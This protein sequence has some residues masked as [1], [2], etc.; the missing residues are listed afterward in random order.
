MDFPILSSIILLPSLGAL[1]LFF[2]KGSEGKS[3]LTIKYVALF[4]TITNFIISLYLWYLF[5]ESSSNF[6]FIEDKEWL[7][8]F[9]NYKVGIDGISILFIILTTF[10]TPLCVLSVNNSIKTRLKDFL[11]AILLMESFEN[12]LAATEKTLENIRGYL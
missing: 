3:L 12:K 8:G 7:D 9:I 1:F 5:D 11:L 2:I 6:Q 10:I 4:V